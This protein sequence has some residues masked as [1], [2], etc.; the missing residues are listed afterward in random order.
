MRFEVEALTAKVVLNSQMATFTGMDM[1]IALTC[2][3]KTVLSMTDCQ[4]VI[5]S[6]EDTLL[7]GE[8]F[9]TLI[10]DSFLSVDT[11]GQPES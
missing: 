3:T 4:E 7:H 2:L 11:S 6:A 1:T 10:A 9:V 5:F 8:K